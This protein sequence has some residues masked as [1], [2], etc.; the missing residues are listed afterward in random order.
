MQTRL[1]HLHT[2]KASAK[3]KG[4]TQAQIGIA[5]GM[6]QGDVSRIFT[7]KHKIGHDVLIELAKA[8]G[9]EIKINKK[10]IKNNLG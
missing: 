4:I 9:C 1:H 8:C 5:L 3:S 10:I 7:G 6:T 2:L